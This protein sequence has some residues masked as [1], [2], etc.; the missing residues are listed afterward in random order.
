VDI[1]PGKDALPDTFADAVFHLPATEPEL[2]RLRPGEHAGLAAREGRQGGFCAHRTTSLVVKP[3]KKGKWRRKRVQRRSSG[4]MREMVDSHR[5]DAGAVALAVHD[6]GGDG[7]P[8]LLAHPTG[9]HGM[10]WQ[11]VAEL[12]VA[13]GRRVYSFDFRGHGD[14]DAPDEDY[15]W[16]HFADDA[17]AVADHLGVAGDPNLLAC[18]HSKGGA[19]LL[20]GEAKRPGAYARIWAFEPIIFPVDAPLPPREDFDLAK[21]ARRRRNEWSS[22][23][24]AFEAYASKPPLAVMTEAS[25]RAYVDYGLRDRGD[26]VYEL[27]CAPEIEAR[28]YSMGPNHGAWTKLPSIETPVLVACGADSHDIGPPLAARIAERLPRGELEVVDGVGH[29]GPQQDPDRIVESM[30]AFATQPSGRR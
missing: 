20:L 10:V 11:P 12:L 17:L 16:H 19:A 22:K 2:E 4:M 29:F 21:T 30:L 14:S 18:G 26:G 28:V 23:D 5:F 8:V 13:R 24:E 6:W 27:K 25:L 3:T 9:F 1:D 7:D 15:S